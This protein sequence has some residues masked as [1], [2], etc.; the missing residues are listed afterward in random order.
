[1]NLT[2]VAA[3]TSW[4]TDGRCGPRQAAEPLCVL[5]VAQTKEKQ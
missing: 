1:M 4:G 5:E 2:Q 3:D